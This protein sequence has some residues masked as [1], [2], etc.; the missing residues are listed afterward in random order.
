MKVNQALRSAIW[1]AVLVIGGRLPALADVPPA[2]TPDAAGSHYDTS[3]RTVYGSQYPVAGKLDIQI[4]SDG[5]VQGYYHNAYEKAFIP[6]SGGRDGTYI[7]FDIGPSAAL[8]GIGEPGGRVHVVGTIAA[9]G[10]ITGQLYPN[11]ITS[12]TGTNLSPQGTHGQPTVILQS[13]ANSD[14]QYL[15]SAKLVATQH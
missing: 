7:W 10:T 5:I 14:D 6:V 13:S 2:A 9:D 11:Y 8:T 15:F 3:I 12:Q 4:S 1:I